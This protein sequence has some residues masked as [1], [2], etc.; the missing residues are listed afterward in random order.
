MKASASLVERD[1]SILSTSKK[2]L[3]VDTSI[4]PLDDS[5]DLKRRK[6]PLQIASSL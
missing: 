2:I 1:N 5:P 4:S 6:K 3:E